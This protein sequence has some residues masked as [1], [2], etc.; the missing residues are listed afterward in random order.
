M[1][2]NKKAET[3]RLSG[4]I[5]RDRGLKTKIIPVKS[6]EGALGIPIDDANRALDSF[7]KSFILQY[8]YYRQPRS[9]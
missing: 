9:G 5:I 8:V 1:A 7:L 6:G 4:E 2:I 3:F